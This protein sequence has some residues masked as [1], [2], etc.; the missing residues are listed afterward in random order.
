MPARNRHDVL[1]RAMM[2]SP[3]FRR[4]FLLTHMDPADLAEIDLDGLETVSETFTRMHQ[5]VV[6]DFVL[7]VPLKRAQGWAYIITDQETTPNK[8]GTLKRL[9]IS[10]SRIFEYD[11][12]DPTSKVPPLIVSLIFCTGASR[13]TS[14]VDGY[15]MLPEGLRERVRDWLG[16]PPR[17]VHVSDL[18]ITENLIRAC[19]ELVM[20]HLLFQNASKDPKETVV[21]LEPLFSVLLKRDGGRT[22]VQIGIDYLC[23]DHRQQNPQDFIL[24]LKK[25]L[26]DRDVRRVIMSLSEAF[27]HEGRQEGM[28]QGMQE[29]KLETARNM[30]SKGMAV[31]TIAEVTG[32]SRQKL[33][34]LG[35][36]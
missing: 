12:N 27:R 1:Y 36:K 25:V 3:S 22:T 11:L 8:E 13:W 18:E 33:A 9:M 24:K 2:R 23:P 17:V 5:T 34:A 19:P 10:K 20:A 14:E 29:G 7:R 6:P 16:E 4:W 21:K 32:L 30:L 28:Q 35:K 26:K 31:T 15:K